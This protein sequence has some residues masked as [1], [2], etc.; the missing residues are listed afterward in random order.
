LNK[1]DK[2]AWYER[3]FEL[4]CMWW[5]SISTIKLCDRTNM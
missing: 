3:L 2:N 4:K 1:L 5:K